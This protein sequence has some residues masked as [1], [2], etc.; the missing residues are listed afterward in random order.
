[1]TQGDS[2]VPASQEQ[3]HEG[4]SGTIDHSSSPTPSDCREPVTPGNDGSELVETEQFEGNEMHGQ[5]HLPLHFG[6]ETQILCM[7]RLH[8]TPGEFTMEFHVVDTNLDKILLWL[9]APE[10]VQ[11]MFIVSTLY[12]L[13]FR[14]LPSLDFDIRPYAIQQGE[15]HEHEFEIVWQFLQPVPCMK[16][17]PVL[18]FSMN[19]EV[20]LSFPPEASGHLLDISQ[21]I[22]LGQ[23]KLCFSQADSMSEYVLALYSHYPT[24]SQIEPLRAHWD[25]STRF[26]QV[27]AWLVCPIPPDEW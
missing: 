21:Y 12:I 16:I 11:Y 4:G 23:N 19:D 27:M 9:R 10:S 24:E 26:R 6:K 15:S 5:L 20:M 8:N 22:R 25:V 14:V 1:M 18:S 2:F 13:I 3:E 7:T 17:P